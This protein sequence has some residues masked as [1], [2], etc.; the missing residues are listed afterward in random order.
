MVIHVC[1]GS[2]RI[3][4]LT[5]DEY[6]SEFVQESQQLGPVKILVIHYL[7]QMVVASEVW[8]QSGK[9]KM[10]SLYHHVKMMCLLNTNVPDCGQVYSGL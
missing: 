8:K 2:G 4:V 9:T 10:M 7:L 1:E 5:G 3:L 6:G